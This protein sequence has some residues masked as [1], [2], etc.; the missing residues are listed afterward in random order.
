[1]EGFTLKEKNLITR[2]LLY[3]ILPLIG[4]VINYYI[5]N[6]SL[7]DN[8]LIYAL[9]FNIINITGVG[10]LIILL[11]LVLAVSDT[12]KWIKKYYSEKQNLTVTP[13]NEKI[14]ELKEN[15]K[16]KEDLLLAKAGSLMD[17]YND[18]QQYQEKETLL[19]HLKRFTL[20]KPVIHSAQL[21]R[22]SKK[23]FN[24]ETLVKVNYINGYA[25]E[26]IDINALIQTYYHIPKGIYFDMNNILE[27]KRKLDILTESEKD[28]ESIQVS[29]EIEHQV[30]EDILNTIEEFI[31]TYRPLIESKEPS[32]LTESDS[33]IIALYELCVEIYLSLTD[34]SDYDTWELNFFTP[35]IDHQLKNMKR[36]GI[37]SGILKINEYIFRNEGLSS[38]KGRIYITRCF[39]LNNQNYII[40]LS[41]LPNIID[42]PNWRKL[43]STQTKEL[44]QG[45]QDDLSLIYNEVEHERMM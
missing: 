24:D 8:L 9:K 16:H 41:I 28:F 4:L 2:L 35:E 7:T 43:L 1:L 12:S 5:S 18:L 38:K 44:I 34:D 15:I 14:N 27:L 31:K 19:K 21:Y 42:F 6:H 23:I 11:V 20:N 36:T 39:Q 26:G 22:Y 45:L 32:S 25:I 13:L 10:A 30:Q 37:L 29:N 33:Y 3:S 40:L 17:K